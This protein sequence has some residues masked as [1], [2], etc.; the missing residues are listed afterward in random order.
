MASPAIKNGVR[1]YWKLIKNLFSQK[2][3]AEPF[4]AVTFYGKP[5]AQYFTILAA[6]P[7]I[8]ILRPSRNTSDRT[9]IRPFP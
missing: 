4:S 6:S 8:V 3:T 5:L 2:A 9:D 1:F 7:S